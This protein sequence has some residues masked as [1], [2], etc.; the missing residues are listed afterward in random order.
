MADLLCAAT[1]LALALW[2]AG[3]QDPA[4]DA[5]R[6]FHCDPARGNMQNDGSAERPWRTVEEVLAAGLVQFRDR[7]GKAANENAPVRPGDTILLRSGYHG[8]IRI[9]AGYNDRFI[10]LAADKGHAPQVGRVEIGEGRRWRVR[11]LTVSPSLAPA[12]PAKPPGSLVMLG[13]RGGEES[14]ELVVEDCFI[15]SVRDASSW[16]ARDWVDK[17]SSGIWLGRHGKGH[18]ARNNY[19]LNTRFGINLCAPEVVCEGN[20]VAHFSGDGIRVTRDG[21]VVQ[22]NV[23]KNVHVSAADGDDNHDDGIQAFLF[24]KGTGT[25]RNV[26]VRGNIILN[27]EDPRQPFPNA[28][29]GIGFF[30]G[31]LIGFLVEKNVVWTGHWHGISL[32]DAQEC[33]ILDNAC[34]CL[35]RKDDAKPWIMLGQKLGQARGNTVLNNM[36]HTFDFKADP[37]VVQ[38][39]NTPVKEDAFLRRLAELEALISKKFGKIHPAAK[40][41]RLGPER[42]AQK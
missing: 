17:P 39:N 12:P 40:L 23:V 20:V 26:T 38:K 21:Q 35:S 1:A 4:P 5:G 41:P 9:A 28:M 37:E 16:T 15:Y 24:N 32:Y 6:V 13:E 8:E 30:D 3:P 29:Q 33:R 31:P 14:E 7:D 10:T 22:Y 36:A 34:R 18:A 25:M 19:V 11:G 2:P 27:R 42:P